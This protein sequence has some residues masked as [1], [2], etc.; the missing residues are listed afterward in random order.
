MRQSS[1]KPVL[2]NKYQI[3]AIREIQE[4]ERANSQLGVAPSIHAIARQLM[5]KALEGMKR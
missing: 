2:L 4:Q 1:V 5:D 3:E